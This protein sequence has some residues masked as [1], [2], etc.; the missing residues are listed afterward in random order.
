MY[1]V[2]S[3]SVIY[4]NLFHIAVVCANSSGG[5]ALGVCRKEI[6]NHLANY[7]KPTVA[8][9]KWSMLLDN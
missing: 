3:S 7:N 5:I 6:Q 9:N 2:Q 4:H 8:L 1:E